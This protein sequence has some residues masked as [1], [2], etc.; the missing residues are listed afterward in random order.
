MPI[1]VKLVPSSDRSTLYPLSALLS[2]EGSQLRLIWL[3]DQAVAVR[4]EGVVGGVVSGK[5]SISNASSP[6]R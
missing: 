5:D 3:V 6:M 4:F 2:E 1:S